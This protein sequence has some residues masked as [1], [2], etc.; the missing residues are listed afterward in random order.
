MGSVRELIP[1]EPVFKVLYL[2]F[3]R[4]QVLKINNDQITYADSKDVN[5][6]YLF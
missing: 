3:I 2:S 1:S 6:V 5:S 4:E